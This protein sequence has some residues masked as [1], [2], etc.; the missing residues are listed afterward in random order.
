MGA[1]MHMGAYVSAYVSVCGC[2][3]VCACVCLCV[4]SAA[5]RQGA[6]EPLSQAEAGARS[7]GCVAKTSLVIRSFQP[8]GAGPSHSQQRTRHR[9]WPKDAPL[10]AATAQALTPPC[11]PDALPGQRAPGLSFPSSSQCL[12]LQI[13]AITGESLI[14]AA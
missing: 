11:T 10:P 12:P 3:C 13:R 14:N 5:G 6:A 8:Q 4:R 7:Q 1:C 2:M 9:G